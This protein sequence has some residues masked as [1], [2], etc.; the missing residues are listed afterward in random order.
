[1]SQ[2]W[3][4]QIEGA[5]NHCSSQCQDF[6]SSIQELTQKVSQL[7]LSASA[8]STASLHAS[9]A[10]SRFTEPRMPP[11]ERFSGD[12]STCRAFLT[13]CSIQFSLQP[14]AFPSE[15][16]KVA[17]VISLLTGQA[18]R[19]ATAEWERGSAIRFSFSDFAAELRRVFDPVRPEKEAA[20]LLASLRQGDKSVDQY[21][22]E[23]RTLAA[24][25]KWNESACFD[26]FYQGLSERLKDELAARDLPSTLHALIDLASRIDRRLRERRR[27]RTVVGSYMSPPNLFPLPAR[28]G[29]EQTA[30]PMQLGRTRLTPEERERRY[31]QGL[32]FYCSNQGHQVRDCPVKD[33]AQR[34]RGGRC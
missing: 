28:S 4:N 19:W 10:L 26:L 21:A 7:T 20:R 8:T 27:E 11:P 13:Q 9:S 14:S 17:Y 22:I 25:T 33:V 29:S 6:K 24:D 34:G 23:F 18:L 12:A 32:C 5:L 30:E 31:K 15:E 1:M 2:E 16:T 3:Q